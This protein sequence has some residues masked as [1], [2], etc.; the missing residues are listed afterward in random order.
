MTSEQLF[1]LVIAVV[2]LVAVTVVATLYASKNFHRIKRVILD[3]LNIG[4][5][6]G[7]R[8]LPEPEPVSFGTELEAMT[9][10]EVEAELKRL[11]KLVKDRK[12]MAWET[13]ISH[14]LWGLYKNILPSTSLYTGDQHT[15][16]GEWYAVK[17]LQVSTH[18]GLHTC[19]FELKG[20]KYKFVD[21]EE[22]QNWRD[23]VKLFSLFL[24]EDSGRCLIEIPMKSK[25]EGS[26]RHYS[27]SSGGPNA[28]L[29]GDWINDFINVKL[30]HQRLHNRE[31]RA[32]KHQAR[33]SEIEDLK[34]KFGILD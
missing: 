4:P 8:E 29:P 27:V 10:E 26:G 14:H 34:G 20:A 2:A 32:Q 24:Y 11:Y 5:K 9:E 28:L 12:K 33:L 19:E 22:R 23:K 21:D 18:K 16:G 17:V 25:I 31:I 7:R 3:Q 13:D 6:T 1:V 30:K 15:Q